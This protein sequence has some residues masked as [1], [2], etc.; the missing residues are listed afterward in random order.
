M[1]NNPSSLICFFRWVV[2]SVNGLIKKWKAFDCVFPNSQIPFIGDYVRI[3]CAVINAFKPPRVFETSTDSAQVEIMRLRA[4]QCNLLQTFVEENGLSSRSVKNW[5][6][7]SDESLLDFPKLTLK[8]LRDLTLGIYQV[9]DLFVVA[10]L[11]EY[12]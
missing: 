9:S 5:E 7:V 2:E 12:I 1:F 11:F 6:K 4:Q 10:L 3:I 8:D